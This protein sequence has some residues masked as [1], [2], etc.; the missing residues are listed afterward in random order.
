MGLTCI[1]IWVQTAVMTS[2]ANGY[3]GLDSAVADEIKSRLAVTRG[4]T[5]TSAADA[6]NV[7]RA[8]LSARVNGHAPFSPSLLAD[9][10]ALLGTT[11]SEVMAAAE[12]RRRQGAGEGTNVPGA[13]TEE[14][15]R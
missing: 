8:T 4:V 5:V 12:R 7:R 10:A 15:A 11:A 6:L 1:R 3:A 14:V 13:S 2:Y 9:M